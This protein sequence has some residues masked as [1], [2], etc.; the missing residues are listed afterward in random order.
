MK[1]LVIASLLSVVLAV[2]SWADS[3]TW[4]LPAPGI[5]TEENATAAEKAALS[6][7]GVVSAEAFVETHTI[8][9]EVI[10]PSIPLKTVTRAI[11]AAGY[12]V[13]KPK[14]KPA[15]GK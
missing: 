12:T 14:G 13:G 9:V 8:E 10:D 6:V 11:N 2:A 7:K 4:V 15:S 3:R 5:L 1:T